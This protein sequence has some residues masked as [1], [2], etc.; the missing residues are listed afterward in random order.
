MK[1]LAIIAA[2]LLI[3]IAFPTPSAGE[4]HSVPRYLTKEST[5]DMKN[6]NRIF[7]GWVNLDPDE[8][9]AHG[10][11]TKTEWTDII[12]FL[13]AGFAS[14]LQTTYLSGRTIVAAAEEHLRRQGCEAVDI[15]VLNLRPELPPIYRRHGYIETGTEA[16]HSPRPLKS[17][18]ECHCIVMSKQL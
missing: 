18:T 12:A 11:A 9:A 15:L 1:R 4:R 13:N 8:W 10:Y 3:C 6:M 5:V 16:F 14:N 17:G 7:V 2:L